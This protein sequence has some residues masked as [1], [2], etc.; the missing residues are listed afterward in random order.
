MAARRQPRATY[1][2]SPLRALIRTRAGRDACNA[3]SAVVAQRLGIR[4]ESAERA[5]HRI[6]AAERVTLGVAD[7]WA[8]ALGSHV[9]ELYGWE[10]YAS[11]A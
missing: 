2:A 6:M 10:A 7:A 8:T 5:L 3:V 1:P 4:P 11:T 9:G